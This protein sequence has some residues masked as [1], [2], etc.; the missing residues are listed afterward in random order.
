MHALIACAEPLSNPEWQLRG[1]RDRR[2]PGEANLKT[3]AG[4]LTK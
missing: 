4:K 3:A 2:V 1:H